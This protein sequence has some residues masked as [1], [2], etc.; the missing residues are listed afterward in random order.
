MPQLYDPLSQEDDTHTGDAELQNADSPRAS[1][2]P[3]P[4]VYYGEGPFSVPSSDD[5][6]EDEDEDEVTEKD[7]SGSLNRAETG[8]LFRSQLGDNGLY[9]GGQKEFPTVRG[10]LLALAALMTLSGVIGL[11][12]A[13]S[14]KEINRALPGS[15]HITMDH[16]F[17]NT[18]AVDRTTL[19]WVSE[20]GDGV[21]SVYED[22][23]IKLVNL[24][25]NTTTN[26]VQLS[27]LKDEQGNGLGWSSW[28]LSPDMKYMLIKADH[29]KQWRWSSFGNYWIFNLETKETYPLV[30]PSN[31]PTVAYATWSPTGERI[32]YVMNNDLYVVPT[33]SPRAYHIP[34]T[35]S[36]NATLFHGVPDWV[37]EEEVFSDDVALWW[38]PDSSKV[39]FLV[40]DE[41]L[42]EEYTFPIYN[43]TPDSDT[44]VP[45][46]KQLTMRYPKP[47]YPNPL[48]SVHVFD[49]EE[50]LSDVE[51]GEDPDP[52][53][54]TL[55]LEWAGRQPAND[56]IITD[57]VWL[58][59][60]TLLLKEVNRNAEA[61]SAI[62]FDVSDTSL[63]AAS[64]GRVVRTLGKDGEEA[65]E[66]W[67]ESE[68][69]VYSLSTSFSPTGL[70]SY[71]DV[72]PDKDG[73]NHIALFS[74]ASTSTPR[75]L[76][77]GPWEVTGGVQAVDFERGLVYFQAANP[78]SIGRNIF[79]IPLPLG[80]DLKFTDVAPI[81][82]LTA[83]TDTSSLGK[84]SADFS[85]DAGFYMLSY[86]GPNVPWQ[87]V[88]KT[89]DSSF[90]FVVNDNVR[91]N[92]TWSQFETPIHQ[93]TTIDSDGYE[94]NALE[95]RP[96]HM[97]D[98]GRTKYP[99][100]FRVYGGPNSQLVSASFDLSWH[101]YLA[102]SLQYVIVVVDGRGTGFKGRALR[103]PVKGNLG[104]WEVRDQVNAAR[105][106]AAKD[107]VD[108]NRIGI[109]GWSYGGFMSSKVVEADAGIHSLAMAVAPVTSW[110]LY[111]SIYT[112]R[113]MGLPELNP[114][115]YVNASISNVTAFDKV[116]YLL[117]HGSGDDNVHFANSAHLLDMFTKAHVR[118]YQ[119][120]MFTD[121]DHSI[122][123][124]GAYRE[125]LEYMTN[126]LIE[127]WGKGGR[128][129]GW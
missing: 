36:G 100:L 105:L 34:V 120:R 127:K 111:D 114:G 69:T 101:A 119:F 30:P 122:V 21:Y 35:N 86:D 55:E 118:N 95:L 121:S 99:V 32:A 6:D 112:E 92:A 63:L 102:C 39:A 42:V 7:T 67:I 125:L 72:V 85:P 113:Y 60:G 51:I 62:L 110:R 41:T 27:D 1:L 124:R 46:T 61:G 5:E 94:L 66:G 80:G 89:N 31:P 54:L 50:F 116:D 37:Y 109:W 57:V 71:L 38:S 104:F 53:E 14:Y 88:I 83:L 59:D 126:F 87:R 45:Y 74:P 11:F 84:Y 52:V 93:Y 9:V 68:H 13:F 117:A 77:T 40:F 24:N 26:L 98:S 56:S 70:P 82:K 48:V 123:K 75:F 25:S 79:S 108:P 22:G 65:D 44:V 73:Y 107:Y 10:L 58:D 103:N 43:P 78:S 81:P 33:P 90:D 64:S 97:D 8:G 129:R 115:G 2:L 128:R 47:G 49:L 3:R 29:L 20:A 17:N 12:A 96:P 91:L 15:E 19:S 28:K 106:W 16:I 76:T 23:F 18:F 4:T